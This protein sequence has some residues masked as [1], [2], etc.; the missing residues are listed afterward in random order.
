MCGRVRC[1]L[2]REQLASTSNVPVDHWAQG[3]KLFQPSNNITPG[4]WLPVMRL[5]SQ[6]TTTAAGHEEIELCAM[7]CLQALLETVGSAGND[8]SRIYR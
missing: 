1:Y 3:L 5:A 8:Y 6:D 4:G 7:R 2:S